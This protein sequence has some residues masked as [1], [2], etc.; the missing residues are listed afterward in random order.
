MRNES[1]IG[2][3]TTVSALDARPGGAFLFDMHGPDGTVFP[4][5]AV[6]TEVEEPERLV[7]ITTRIMEGEGEEPQLE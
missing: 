3:T 4:M 2:F 6:F 1:P 7:F 5:E